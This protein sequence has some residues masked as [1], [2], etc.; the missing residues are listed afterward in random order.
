MLVSVN[1]NH[2]RHTHIDLVSIEELRENQD[3][4]FRLL[5]AILS[6]RHEKAPTIITRTLV[7]LIHQRD[8]EYRV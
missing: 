4:A 3:S 1:Y 5:L 8:V 6:Y 7:K 2:V